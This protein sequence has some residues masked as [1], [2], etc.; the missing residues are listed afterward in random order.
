VTDSA[1]TP[2]LSEPKGQV[3]LDFM[4]ATMRV[5]IV[6]YD[7]DGMPIRGMQVMNTA[8][9]CARPYYITSAQLRQMADD[10]DAFEVSDERPV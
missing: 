10:A 2:V 7:E 9:A 4:A 5:G 6:N 3:Q 8:L 1:K